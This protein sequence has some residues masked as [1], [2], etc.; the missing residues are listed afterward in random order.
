M[1]PHPLFQDLTYNKCKDYNSYEVLKER[2]DI[3]EI[4]GSKDDTRNEDRRKKKTT[5]VK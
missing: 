1:K 3:H 5:P 2:L 4:T